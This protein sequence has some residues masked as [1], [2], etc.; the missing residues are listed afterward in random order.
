MQGENPVDEGDYRAMCRINRAVRSPGGLCL[1]ERRGAGRR[2]W[3]QTGERLEMHGDERGAA[4]QRDDLAANGV[5]RNPDF[6]DEPTPSPLYLV[7]ETGATQGYALQLNKAPV[8]LDHHGKDWGCVLFGIIYPRVR[9]T[10]TF[11]VPSSDDDDHGDT[12]REE[13]G[14]VESIRP[15][16]VVI[17]KLNKQVVGDYLA[18]GGPE[19]PY[20]EIYRAQTLGDNQHVLQFVDVLEDEFSLYMISRQGLTLRD[21]ILWGPDGGMPGPSHR[22]PRV[23][24]QILDVVQYLHRHDICHHDLSPDN[25]LFLPCEGSDV[26]DEEDPD[27]PLVVYDLAMSLLMPSA[28]GVLRAAGFFGKR[29][30]QPPEGIANVPYDG[31]A[32]DL[33]SCVLILYN[34]LTGFV[35]YRSPL[36]ADVCFLYFI[37]ARGLGSVPDNDRAT[38]ILHEVERTVAAAAAEEANREPYSRPD[39]FIGNP[40]EDRNSDDTTRSRSIR[41]RTTGLADVVNAIHNDILDRCKAHT[42]LSEEAIELLENCLRDARD[43]RWSVQQILESRFVRAARQLR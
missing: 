3:T 37:L 27:T 18:R 20:K 1:E 38:E 23:F 9:G 6:L 32:F 17:K 5:I 28:D 30:Y 24:S 21:A 8:S 41:R 43:T 34:M 39:Y 42:R 31:R 10:T 22:A 16:R 29:A 33:W 13:V 12:N 36:R 4:A 26:V 14:G 11:V 15:R 40:R 19:N 7:A 2:T 25:F 35:L